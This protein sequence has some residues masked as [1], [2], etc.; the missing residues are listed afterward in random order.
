M[1][2]T[3]RGAAG[4]G[5]GRGGRHVPGRTPAPGTG[6]TRSP[7][8][9]DWRCVGAG[10]GRMGGVPPCRWRRTGRGRRAGRRR[11][12][13]G[14]R[15]CVSKVSQALRSC[16]WCPAATGT[17][18]SFARWPPFSAVGTGWSPTPRGGYAP[19][20]L[21]DPAEE[22]SVETHGEDGR[23]THGRVSV[24]LPGPW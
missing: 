9:G 8:D 19:S 15:H 4:A 13:V 14:P 17:A 2:W 16:W 5:P 22:Q 1:D 21:D 24:G 20:A 3:V 11:L 6:K 12:L 18:A 7:F 10:P 23:F